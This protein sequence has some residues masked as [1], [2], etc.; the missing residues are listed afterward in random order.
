MFLEEDILKE[1]DSY[2]RKGLE[3]IL[4]V[5]ISDNIWDQASLP[6]K[7]GGLGIRKT[8][9]LSISAYISS[10]T[11]AEPGVREILGL[12]PFH[13]AGISGNFVPAEQGEEEI[14]GSTP[15]QLADLPGNIIEFGDSQ[16]VG[17]SQHNII[18]NSPL[19]YNAQNSLSENNLNTNIYFVQV[20][21]KWK[22][23]VSENTEFP[24]NQK[25]S[26]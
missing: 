17:L 1:Y 8:T 23:L 14:H 2:I 18:D 26:K 6:T 22:E 9:E 4:N 11:S 3:A 25:K 7:M 24:S 20:K 12:A 10:V 19:P 15:L 5:K 16:D 21:N 13:G